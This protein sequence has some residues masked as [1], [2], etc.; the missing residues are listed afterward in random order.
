NADLTR[1]ISKSIFITNFPDVTTSKDLWVLCQAYGTVVDVFIPNRKSKAGKR[2]AFVRFVKVDN[3]ERLVGNLWCFVST[4]SLSSSP[5]LVLDDSC[6]V[7]RDL[8]NFVMGEVRLFSSINNLRVLLHNEGFTDIE[9]VYLGGLWVPIKLGS[10]KAKLNF[11]KHTGVASWFVRICNAQNDFVANDRIVWVDIEGVPLHAW[12]NATFHKTGTQWGKI[13]NLEDGNDDLFARKRL[14]IKTKLTNNILVSFKIIVKGKSES[15]A[16]SDTVFGDNGDTLDHDNEV[17][18]SL[19]DKEVSNDPF[20]IYELLNKNKKGV[21]NSGKEYSIPYPP[22]FTP[23]QA[24]VTFVQEAQE[25]HREDSIH[26]HHSADRCSSR[27]FEAVEKPDIN[28]QPD[29]RKMQLLVISVYAPQSFTSKRLLWDFI[30]SLINQWNGE[31]LVMG[32]F[33]EVRCKEDRWGSTFH[34][35]GARLFNSFISN[36]GLMEVQLEGYSFTWTHPSASKMSKL[37]RFLVSDGFLYLFP[38]ISAVC[39]DRHLS[40]HRPILLREMLVDFGATPFCNGMI[41]FKKKLQL[42]K[43]EMRV[44]VADY[45]RLQSNNLRDVKN[46]PS[47]IDKLLDQGGVTED[48]LFSRMEA[49]KQLQDLNSSANSDFIQKDKVRWAIEG[50]ENSKFFH[51]IIRKRANLS[52]KGIMIDEEWVDDPIRVKEEFR[53]HFTDRFNDPGMRHGRISFDF[54]N[55]LNPEQVY[56]LETSVS[57]EE[58]RKAAWACG[59]NKSPGPDGFTFEFFRKF[60]L[61]VGPDFCIVVKWFFDH[62]VF[63]TGCNFFFV[64]LIP[65]TLDP[66]LVSEFRPISLIGSLYKVVTKILATRLSFVISNLISNVQSTFL[67]NRQILDDPFIINEILARCKHK[68]HQAMFFK[69]DFAKAY[70]SIIWDYL[71]DVLSAFGFGSRWRSWIRGSLNSGKGSILV[72]GS[73]TS[74]FQFHRGLI[75]GD[76]LAHFLFILIMESLHLAFNRAVDAGIFSDAVASLGCSVMKT[77]FNYLGIMLISAIHGSSITDINTSYLSTWNSIIKEFNSLKV[78]GVDVFSHCKI[79]IEDGLLTRFWKDLWIEDC[80]LLEVV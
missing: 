20:K 76:P 50:D 54:P 79:R 46:K 16:V 31:C 57:N 66:K 10:V 58:I 27:I 69:V 34:A 26:S 25:I 28:F 56:D 38:H 65:K 37:V 7:E 41:R 70:D 1:L 75:Q 77:P 29:G 5:A 18:Q 74:E 80:S 67:P 78:L 49:M 33:N 73:S 60:W 30:T 15:E 35:Q 40:D 44:W 14:C 72:N 64:T 68:N 43:K 21:D 59:E 17:D 4:I 23:D 6:L 39:L 3:V 63:A 2:S 45:K 51:R 19:N 53:N 36:A 47:D 48:V 24:N 61:V 8:D 32:D 55:R 12:S 11:M 42:L 52:V 13:L 62:G 71:D 9:I 22:G